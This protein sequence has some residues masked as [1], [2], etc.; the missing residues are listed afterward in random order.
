MICELCNGRLVLARLH[1]FLRFVATTPRIFCFSLASF[2][3]HLIDFCAG[4]VEEDS[5]VVAATGNFVILMLSLF[6]S[7]PFYV[8]AQRYDVFFVDLFLF[9][10]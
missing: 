6:C 2:I 3:P 5:I 1:Y 4:A 7:I 9:I 10:P 8:L